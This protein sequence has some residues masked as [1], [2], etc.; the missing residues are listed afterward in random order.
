MDTWIHKKTRTA[1]VRRVVAWGV[2]LVVGDKFLIFKTG[3]GGDAASVVEGRLVPWPSELENEMFGSK[4]MQALRSR[5]YPF[6]VQNGSF[7]VLG[8]WVIAGA[9]VLAG[10]LLWKGV[11]AWRHWRDP[12]SHPLLARVG[13]WGDPLGVAVEAERDFETPHLKGGNGCGVGDKYL[14]QSTF[15]GFDMLRL[16]DLLWGYKKITKHSV[17]FIPTGKTYEA[18]VACYG[19]TATIPGKEKKVHELLA[20]VQERAPWAM[21]GYSDELSALFNKRRQE[22]VSSVEQRR[23]EWARKQT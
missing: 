14:I 19:G 21:Y 23:Q 7:H 1:S 11:P 16:Q 2:A 15:F 5:F 20:F 4:E 13:K 22:F 18:I 17:N 6:Y 8:Y 9:L 10:L 12:S 3:G